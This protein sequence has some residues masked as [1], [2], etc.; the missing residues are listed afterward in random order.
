[1]ATKPAQYA[2][3]CSGEHPV[4]RA[5]HAAGSPHAMRIAATQRTGYFLSNRAA[6][7]RM[8]PKS[9]TPGWMANSNRPLGHWG[10][11]R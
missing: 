8:V 3:L 10:R 6:G 4:R 2:G 9:L 5:E 7:T 11:S 1:M